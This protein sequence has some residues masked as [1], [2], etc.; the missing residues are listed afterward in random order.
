MSLKDSISAEAA[1][2]IDGAPA[3]LDDATAAAARLLARSHQPLI[4]GLGADID[5][6]RAAIALAERV[7]G[8]IEHM[9]SAA[10]LRDLNPMRETGIMLTTPGEARVRAD[11]VLLVGDGLT[12]AWPALNERLLA[13]PARPEDADVKR[14]IVWLAPQADA[15]VPGFDGDV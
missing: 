13:P 15:T 9:H 12:E 7:G 10:L 6:A 3:S 4:A 5:G 14:R 11:V 2:S 8:V 1:A